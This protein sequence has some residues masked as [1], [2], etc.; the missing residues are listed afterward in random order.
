L[1]EKRLKSEYPALKIEVQNVAAEWH[2]SQHDLIKLMFD[3]R[4]FS[5]DLV[6][7]FHGINDLIRSFGENVFSEGPYR[8]DYRHYFGAATNLARPG[9]TAMNFFNTAGGHWCSD[10]RFQQVRIAGP[11]GNGL[12]GMLTMF[13]PKSQAVEFTD[14]Q[15]LPA[16]ERNEREFVRI[17]RQSG[18]EVM[19]ATQPSLFRTDLSKA[20]QEVLIFA[21]THQS[22]G[23]HASLD[24]MVAGMQKF[25][26]VTRKIAKDEPI[27]FV[28]LEKEVPKTTEYVYDD[29]H[30]TR[31]GNERVAEVIGDEIVRAELI[32]K[33]AAKRGLGVTAPKTETGG[34]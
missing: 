25:N 27:A 29:V 5:P 31:R 11:E 33:I 6:I 23:K 17:A 1:L 12:N 16:F 10:F 3:A 24:S 18:M 9:R 34:P 20:D 2:T 21:K 22:Q 14:W 8:Q 26:D 19:L 4:E 28:D 15:S 30:F 13:F 7:M 32:P